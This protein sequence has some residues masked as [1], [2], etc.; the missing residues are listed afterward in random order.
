MFIPTPQ[1]EMLRLTQPMTLTATGATPT[2]ASG[3][4]G[5]FDGQS[6][7]GFDHGYGYAPG[8]LG[9]P[10]AAVINTTAVKT[11]AG[12]ESYSAQLQE[13]VD[14]STWVNV[15]QA[16]LITA[17]GVIALSGFKKARYSRVLMTIGGTAPTITFEAYMNPNVGQ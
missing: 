10:W 8:G 13:S 3:S 17:V 14:G 9:K 2:P 16:V 11:T 12:N 15:G 7:G 5:N 6:Q 1:D 4:P